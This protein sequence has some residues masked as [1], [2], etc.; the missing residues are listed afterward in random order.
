MTK[1]TERGPE[2]RGLEGRLLLDRFQVERALGQ[3]GMGEVLLARDT[4]LHRQVALK[5]LSADGEEHDAR[6]HAILKEARRASQINDPHI[7]AIY[8]VLELDDDVLIVM[9]YVEGTTLRERMS[10]PIAMDELWDIATQCAEAMGVAHAHGVIHRDLKPEN[11]MLTRNGGIKVLDFGIAR[12]SGAAHVGSTTTTDSRGP[13]VEGTPQYMAPEVHLAGAIDERAD[14]FSLGVVF[15]EMLTGRNPFAGPTYVSIVFRIAN[16]VPPPVSESNPAAGPEFSRLVERMLAKDPAERIPSAPELLREI[17][18]ARRGVMAP[19]VP[20]RDTPRASPRWL[21]PALLLGAI[22]VVVIALVIWRTA[23]PA[24]PRDLNLALLAPVTPRASEDFAS[25]ALGLS[26]VLHARLHQ[27]T[28]A[29]GFQMASFVDAL[30][31][32]VDTAPKARQILGATVVLIPTLEQ[33]TDVL[34][35]RLT[36]KETGRD[37]VIAERSIETPVTEPFGFYDRI[38]R[39]AARLLHLDEDRRD[40]RT[41]LGITGAGTLR[42]YLEGLGRLRTAESA[43]DAARAVATFEDACRTEPDAAPP[44]AALASAEFRAYRLGADPDGLAKGEAVAREAV[45]RDDRRADVHMALGEMLAAKKDWPGSLVEFQRVVALDSTRDDAM[46]R[47]A[48][49]YARLDQADREIE[50]YRTAI[51]VRPHAWQPYWWL[52]A[53]LY[54]KGDLEE[55]MSAYR[56]MIRRAPYFNEGYSGLGALQVL[57]GEYRP[58]IET[59]KQAVAL[60]PTKAAYENLGTAYFNTERGAEAIEA[61]NQSFQFGKADYQSWLN[62]GDA[63]YWLG[64]DRQKRSAQ[65]AYAQCIQLGRE[66]MASRRQLGQPANVMIPATLS[67]VFPKIG[68]LDSARVYLATALAA[69]SANPLVRF[70]AALAWWQLDERDRAL[71]SLRQA[72]DGGY[73]AA[74]LRDSP[75]FH[76][77]RPVAEFQAMVGKQ[78]PAP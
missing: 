74:W 27:H 40:S 61:Y 20:R 53:A 11:L 6:R 64:S 36:L 30:T 7:A 62:L 71:R 25:F 31:E 51:R 22:A 59:L 4:L 41:L 8:D 49:T 46:L 65:E 75:M 33:D 5:R 52:A 16:T 48:R 63:Y 76:E 60:R 2:S 77:W 68:Q 24:L 54:R 9:E 58:G 39:E 28:R 10:Q 21:R 35:C 72:V 23:G 37:R 67:T 29:P 50:T 78:D 34:R 38:Y 47:V 73:P 15:Y 32:K 70:S 18:E 12:R 14:I 3:G 13:S 66:E 42:F 55:A 19:A 26:D 43:A 1:P 69:D 57:R 44:R 17:R 45:A 56:E